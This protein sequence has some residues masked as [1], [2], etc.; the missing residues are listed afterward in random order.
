MVVKFKIFYTTWAREVACQKQLQNQ[1]WQ[2][3]YHE[4]TFR[5]NTTR[6]GET[7]LFVGD[8]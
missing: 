5:I 6:K 1:N 3:A 4:T 7:V 8:V 2:G